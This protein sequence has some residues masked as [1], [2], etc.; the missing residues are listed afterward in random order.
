MQPVPNPF[1]EPNH[2]EIYDRF[3]P[4]YHHIPCAKLSEVLG[5]EVDSVLD[6]ACGTGHGTEALARVFPDVTGCDLSPAM[7]AVARRHS[8]SQYVEG[9]ASRLPLSGGEVALVTVFMGFH[10]FDQPAFLRDAH[11]VLKPGGFLALDNYGFGGEMAGRPDFSVFNR[12]FYS[13]NFPAPPRNRDWL[14]DEEMIAS[15]F[16]PY[17]NFKYEEEREF[18][19]ADFVGFLTTQ[20]N[21]ITNP[22]WTRAGLGE[23]LT[24]SYGPFFG[25]SERSLRFW[26]WTRVYR[27][28]G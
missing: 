26:G 6:V 13:R 10:W 21:L 4:R 14:P 25:A 5:P 23:L 17:A 11:R 7:L 20:S 22:R 2:A 1:V 3:R 18:G 24:K 27:K 28:I 8:Q 19:L 16:A 12:E 9:S 15:G